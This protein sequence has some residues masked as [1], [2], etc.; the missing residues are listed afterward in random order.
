MLFRS[1]KLPLS[2][3]NFITSCLGL[4]NC[5][6]GFLKVFQI[7]VAPYFKS[8]TVLEDYFLNNVLY[9]AVFNSYAW[10]L[11]FPYKYGL[12]SHDR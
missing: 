2:L 1:V 5:E 3:S 11:K 7:L 9:V 6:E 12:T 8:A 4:K 10:A